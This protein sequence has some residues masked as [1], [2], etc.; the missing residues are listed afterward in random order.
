M[1]QAQMLDALGVLLQGDDVG[2][3]VFMTI[4]AA[5]D[6]LEFDAHGKVSSG[7]EWWVHDAGHSTGVISSTGSCCVTPSKHRLLQHSQASPV[8]TA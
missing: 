1:C 6:E 8:S 2:D 7:V 5:Q 3:G 4:I